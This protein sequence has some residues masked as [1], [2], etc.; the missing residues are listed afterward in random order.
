MISKESF[1]LAIIPR[2]YGFARW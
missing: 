2:D 1:T